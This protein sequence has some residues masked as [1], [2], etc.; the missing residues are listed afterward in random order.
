MTDSGPPGPPA[1][2][3]SDAERQRAVLVLR[4]AVV[5][6]RLTLEEYSDRVG[7]AFAAKTDQDLAVLVRDLPAVPTSQLR[8]Q[9]LAAERAICSHLVRRG[10]L[11]LGAHSAYV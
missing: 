4:D 5:E 7:H 1:I 9:P 8:T 10:P 6:G 11:R 2:R 3:V